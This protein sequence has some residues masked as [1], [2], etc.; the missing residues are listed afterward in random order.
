MKLS[1]LID[2][3]KTYQDKLKIDPKV[4]IAGLPVKIIVDQ[5]F[6]LSLRGGYEPQVIKESVFAGIMFEY[7]NCIDASGLYDLRYGSHENF[8]DGVITIVE[9]GEYACTLHYLY[10]NNHHKDNVGCI[11]ILLNDSIIRYKTNY[12]NQHNYVNDSIL[13]PR[14]YFKK[15]D[16][17]CIKVPDV[18]QIKTRY[19]VHLN[20]S[21]VWK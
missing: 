16:R 4:D 6:N 2:K 7:S 12:I 13:L 10:I 20:K 15:G 8:S 5:D 17:I 3:L 19:Q 21:E 1:E 14:N 18:D 9:S 11:D